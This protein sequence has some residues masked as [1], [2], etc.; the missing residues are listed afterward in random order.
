MN[1]SDVFNEADRQDACILKKKNCN[2]LTSIRR[3]PDF[4][5]HLYGFPSFFLSLLMDGLHICV[6]IFLLAWTAAALAGAISKEENIQTKH[7][8]KQQVFKFLSTL[9]IF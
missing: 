3:C 8:L 9:K 1:K 6:F 7:I 2:K 4:L 5:L